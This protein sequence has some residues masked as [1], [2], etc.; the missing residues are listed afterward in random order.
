M[1]FSSNAPCQ[2]TP[3]LNLCSPFL[4]SIWLAAYLDAAGRVWISW[5][6][7]GRFFP[8]CKLH[9]SSCTHRLVQTT[10]FLC[11]K[12]FFFVLPTNIV[13]TPNQG[14]G[15][16]SGTM[17]NN[18]SNNLNSSNRQDMR[19]TKWLYSKACDSDYVVNLPSVTSLV[20]MNWAGT[21]KLKQQITQPL[22]YHHTY[23]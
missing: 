3:L 12:P 15:E 23:L 22:T 6:R 7:T 1:P 16:G 11:I 4:F 2:F 21:D 5:H 18:Y 13:N 9:Q 14:G 20:T 19:T 17:M 10:W 8:H